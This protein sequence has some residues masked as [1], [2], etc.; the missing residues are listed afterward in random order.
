MFSLQILGRNGTNLM[1]CKRCQSNYISGRIRR[2]L[3]HLHEAEVTSCRFLKGSKKELFVQ[4]KLG[5]PLEFDK[6]D[7]DVPALKY[8]NNRSN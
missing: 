8:G 1:G 6:R 7:Y 4:T 5:T 3:S 2:I